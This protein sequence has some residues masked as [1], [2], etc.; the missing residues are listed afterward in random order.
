MGEAMGPMR[1]IWFVSPLIV[2]AIFA[3]S[4][5]VAAQIA[6]NPPPLQVVTPN[7]ASGVQLTMVN[8]TGQPVDVY[9]T[10]QN[11]Q[12][13]YVQ[14]LQVGQSAVLPSTPGQMLIFGINR[15]PFM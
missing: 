9:G 4:G 10:D 15:Q 8:S 1:I 7:Q 6:I 13:A 5:P 14:S 11:G 3:A 12:P 2:A